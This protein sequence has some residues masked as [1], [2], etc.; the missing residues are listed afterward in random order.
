[1]LRSEVL[2]VLKERG[3]EID[4]EDADAEWVLAMWDETNVEVFFAGEGEQPMRQVLVDDETSLWTGRPV[5]NEP[6]HV[7]LGILGDAA[8]DA[9]WRPECAGEERFTDLNPPGLGPFSDEVLLYQGTLWLPRRNLG[10]VMCEGVV[11]SIVWRR[12]EDLPRQFV[13]PVTEVQKQI[14]ARSDREEYLWNCIRKEASAKDPAPRSGLQGWLLLAFIAV[15][16]WLGWQAFLEQQRWH[17]APHIF[18][19]VT[20]IVDT[21]KGLAKKIYRVSFPDYEG[22]AHT[23]DLEPGEFY[24]SPTAVGEDVEL[25]FVAGDPPR[26]MG[27][28]RVRDAAFLRYVPWFIG[29]TAAY[30]IL[31]IA[32]R[33]V[34]RQMEAQRGVVVSPVLPTP[35]GGKP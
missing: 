21:P 16:V 7:A 6:L 4:D 17:T 1:M 11:N 20:E 15:L 35:P 3:A 22:R 2:R 34:A 29:A 19:K 5:V 27:P 10:L 32:L 28:S 18:G 24:V 14:S 12:S 31:S 25:A 13:G 30:L 33:F 26:V 23:A 8:R 9:G